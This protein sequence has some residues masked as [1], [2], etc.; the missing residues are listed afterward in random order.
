MS[1]IYMEK[2][3][4]IIDIFDKANDRHSE[5]LPEI[6]VEAE[7]IKQYYREYLRSGRMDSQTAGKMARAKWLAEYLNK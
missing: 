1:K 4:L 3:L 6:R 7:K 2:S 5:V